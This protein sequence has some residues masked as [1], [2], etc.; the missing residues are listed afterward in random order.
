MELKFE[1]LHLSDLIALKTLIEKRLEAKEKLASC[2]RGHNYEAF[3]RNYISYQQDEDHEKLDR[4]NKRIDEFISVMDE[5]TEQQVK[6]CIVTD[7]NNSDP[8]IKKP[9]IDRVKYELK[10]YTELKNRMDELMHERSLAAN[11]SGAEEAEIRRNCYN[12]IIKDL[13]LLVY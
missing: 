5:S 12:G 6:N 11:Y 7:V 10:R 13:K 2:E 1:T 3:E 8:N 4:I 9:L